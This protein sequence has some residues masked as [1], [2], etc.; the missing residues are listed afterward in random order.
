MSERLEIEED[1]RIN[2]YRNDCGPTAPDHAP[3]PSV[4]RSLFHS[5]TGRDCISMHQSE[6]TMTSDNVKRGS[7]GHHTLRPLVRAVMQQPVASL[8]A[9]G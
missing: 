3:S 8:R 9:E 5:S 2:D 4:S 6:M 1:G 7:E